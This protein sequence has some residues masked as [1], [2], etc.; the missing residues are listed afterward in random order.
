MADF[1]ALEQVGVADGTATP[2][3]KLDFRTV[4][5]KKRRVRG[6]KATA[7]AIAA[8][9]RLYIG[10]L[11]QNCSLRAV[12]LV[13]D[14]SLG[15]TTVSIGTTA[16]PAKYVNA[17]TMTTTDVPTGIGPKASAFIL[18]PATA[19]EDL[20]AT[21]AVAGIAGGVVLAF[22]YEYSTNN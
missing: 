20:W 9:D 1:F 7:Q 17:K 3:K 15:A 16:V 12:S 21:F 19:D 22:D 14:T 5:G 11:P 18:D 6:T 8:G 2:P 4:G 10:R 13:S